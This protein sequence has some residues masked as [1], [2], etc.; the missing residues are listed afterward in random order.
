MKFKQYI[1]IT[2]LAG[3]L[4]S[5]S[6]CKKFLEHA[7]D[8][9]TQLDSKE[10]LAQLLVSAY[11]KA[12]YLTFTE[13]SSD[14][15]EDRGPGLYNS[16]GSIEQS[17]VRNY[18]WEDF[19]SGSSSVGG[20]SDN[21][22]AEAYK[23]IATANLA[24]A[25]INANP[26]Q[27]D[28]LP[29]KGEAL[30]ARAYAHFMLVNL[31]AKTFTAAA[32]NQSP[33]VPYLT[34][35]EDVV[36]GNYSRGTVSETYQKIEQDL[37]GGLALIDNSIYNKAPKYHFTSNAAHAFAA[38]FYLFKGEYEKVTA[39]A[40]MVFTTEPET[41]ALLRPWNTTYINASD[42]AFEI[43]FTQS[44]QNSN[45]L[46]SEAPSLW[47][48]SYETR[49]GMG[50]HSRK[51]ILEGRNISGGEYTYRG[52][53]SVYPQ[54]T[55]NKFKELFF[56]STI[57]SGIGNPYVMIPLLTTDELLMNR[58]EAYA[59]SNQ[60]NLALR[61]INIFLSTRIRDYNVASHEVTLNKI[62]VYYNLQDQ[63][64]SLI[65]TI[66][67]LKRAEFMSEGLRWFDLN[68]HGLTITHTIRD[69]RNNLIQT[70]E[71][72]KDDPRRIFQLPK[73]VEKAGLALNPR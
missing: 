22:W 10:K 45:L 2:A 64:Q 14:N 68:R 25:Y 72:R 29:Y 52:N 54:I 44:N 60:Y 51:N 32:A 53:R 38:R 46:I 21:Y 6:S 73:P 56:E 48:R 24:L 18:L 7:P 66:L 23:A 42:P 61:D 59:Q 71:L 20:S 31:F 3:I 27:H 35:V 37:I 43:M 58:A 13:M 4:G 70:L 9:R 33:G 34:E 50:N 17:M 65:N 5:N 57:G 8:L 26:G 63:K 62:A 30:L 41:K 15:V 19:L 47:N 12:D 11:P 49:Y 67:D 40:N 16:L 55:T 36:Q 1:F 28:L 69:D 39:F